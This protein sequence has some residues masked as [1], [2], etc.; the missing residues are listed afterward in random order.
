MG[1]SNV[2]IGKAKT[3]ACA[4]TGIEMRPFLKGFFAFNITATTT[5]A[6]AINSKQQR[7]CLCSKTT[8]IW[9]NKLKKAEP[10]IIIPDI[11]EKILM[12]TKVETIEKKEETKIEKKKETS[13]VSLKEID[14]R[15]MTID[16]FLGDF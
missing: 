14:D 8:S 10:T 5:K 11:T 15:L 12:E 16:D 1:V 6:I 9:K 7:R 13:K 3:E 4:K 2:N